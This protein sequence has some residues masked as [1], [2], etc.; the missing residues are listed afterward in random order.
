MK[1]PDS[2]DETL[3]ECTAIEPA[4]SA[5]AGVAPAAGA[6]QEVDAAEPSGADAAAP[7]MAGSPPGDGAGATAGGKVRSSALE[8]PDI[9]VPQVRRSTDSGNEWMH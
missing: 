9:L 7:G 5:E 6:R 8:H 1:Q 4:T 2:S 3:R